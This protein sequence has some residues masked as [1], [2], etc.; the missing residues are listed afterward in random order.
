MFHLRSREANSSL[1]VVWNGTELTNSTHTNYLGVTLDR[2]LSYK[3]HIQN[4]KMKVTTRNNLL[5]KLSTSK[6]G[7]NFR[8]IRT[9]LALS[10]FMVEYAAPVWSRSS[11]AKKLDPALDQA[12][13]S[14]T[15]CL[16]PTSVENLYLLSRISPPPPPSI[17]RDVCAR[18]ERRKQSS[19]KAH[20]LFDHTPANKPP[21]CTLQPA[22]FP[23]KLIRCSKWRKRLRDRRHIDIVNLHEEMTKSYARAWTTWRCLNRLR[24]GYACSKS[25][26][27][28]WKY[29]TG[30]TMCACRQEEETTSHMMQCLKLAHPCSLDDLIKFN[31]RAKECVD[32]WKHLVS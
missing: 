23:V 28:K 6:W 12:C 10:Y 2:T 30:H 11:H 20:S 22:N 17:R 31:D 9:A 16:K 21:K 3:Q 18:V 15:G 5:T 13:R 14:V 19:N 26:V 29:Y 7:A 8:T 4:T 1:K 25:Q 27:K 24:T 32:M